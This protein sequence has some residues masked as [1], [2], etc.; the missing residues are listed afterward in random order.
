MLNVLLCGALFVIGFCVGR[1]RERASSV[2][3]L[4]KDDLILEPGQL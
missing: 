2:Q 1:A 4:V 3:E